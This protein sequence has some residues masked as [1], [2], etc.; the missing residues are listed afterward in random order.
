[1]SV[2]S[3]QPTTPF[4]GILASFETEEELIHALEAV[5]AEGYDKLDAFTPYPVEHVSELVYHHK[6]S[7]MPK[8]VLGAGLTGAATGFGLQWWTT[9]I[10][11][12]MNIGGRPL[13]SW[14]AWIAVTFELTILFSAFAA[15][16]GMLAVNGLPRPHHPVFNVEAFESASVDGF[17]LLIEAADPKYDAKATRETLEGLGSHEVHDVDW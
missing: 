16:F 3:A 6:K 9:T 13:F 2:A 5:Q 8:L 15:V 7:I 10:A 4:Y 12:P 17:F 11:Y 14:P 1:M